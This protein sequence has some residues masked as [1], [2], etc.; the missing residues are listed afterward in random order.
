MLSLCL[1]FQNTELHRELSGSDKVGLKR[2]SGRNGEGE[3]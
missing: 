2:V 1:L 3:K